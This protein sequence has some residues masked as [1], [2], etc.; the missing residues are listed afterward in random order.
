METE[1]APPFSS[2]LAVN[3]FVIEHQARAADAIARQEAV[4]LQAQRDRVQLANLANTERMKIA[5][6]WSMHLNETLVWAGAG[7]GLGLMAWLA[8]GRK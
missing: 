5:D 1:T 2:P 3:K 7:V 6:A 8:F 4:A